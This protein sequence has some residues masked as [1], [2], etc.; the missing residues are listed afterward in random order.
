M[1]IRMKSAAVA[2]SLVAA[3]FVAGCNTVPKSDEKKQDMVS[4]SDRELQEFVQ[5]DPTLQP[6]LNRSAGYAVFPNVG[7]GGLIAGGAWGRG[8]VYQ[9]GRPIGYASITQG[10]VGAQIGGQVFSELIVLETQEAMNKLKDDQLALA[11]NASA[12]ILKQGVGATATFQNGVA[13]FYRSEA[14]AMLEAAIGGQRFDFEPMQM[15]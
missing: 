15:P 2:A 7:K 5:M 11:A 4:S 14:G 1:S 13:V 12:V 6:L 9:N 8:V 10:T 3:L